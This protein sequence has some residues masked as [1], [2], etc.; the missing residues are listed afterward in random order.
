MLNDMIFSLPDGNGSIDKA[1]IMLH[2]YGS[3]GDDLI[4]LVPALKKENL[5]TVFYAPD[6]PFS[7]GFNAYQW[8][9]LDDIEDCS[10]LERF[11]YVAN[12]MQRA[13]NVVPLIHNFVEMVCKKHNIASSNIFLMGF[14]QGGLLALMS[15]LM[16]PK[17]IGGIIGCS[18]IPIAINTVMLKEEVLNTP[19][20]LLTHG[21]DDRQVPFIATEMTQ[22]T[23]KNLGASVTT[24]AVPGMGHS[25]DSGC[26][27]AISYFLRSHS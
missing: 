22:N 2:G 17:K 8:Y 15:G 19:D 6:A 18:S 10:V 3:N 26:I 9:S 12:L 13:K 21:E 5:N 4:S 7:M 23:L 16:D 14:S 24:Y 25:I 20:A 27:Q 11:E 1:L